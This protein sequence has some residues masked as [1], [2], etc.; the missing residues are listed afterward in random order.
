MF[1]KSV[2]CA[3]IFFVALAVTTPALASY[4]RVPY[5]DL[6]GGSELIVTGRITRLSGDT[7]TLRIDAVRPGRCVAPVTYL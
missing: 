1:Q 5:F 6:I 4:V 2:L 7:F 3:A